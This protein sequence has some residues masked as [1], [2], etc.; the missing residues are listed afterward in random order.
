MDAKV[1]QFIEKHSLLEPGERVLVAY[2]GGPDSACLLVLLRQI[3][4]ATAAVYVNHQLRGEESNQEEEFVR[5]FCV[6]RSIPLYVER[7][8]WKEKPKNLEESARKRRYRNL[9]KVAAEQGFHKVALAHHQDDIAETFLLR[10]IRGSGPY[11]LAG[12][13]P[14]RGI[15]IRPFLEC[16]RVEIL[17]H[18]SKNQVPF[19]QDSTN[20]GLEFRRNRIRSELIPYIEKHFNSAFKETLSRTSLWIHEQNELLSELLTP[21]ENLIYEE[22]GKVKI[23]REPFLRLSSPLRKALFRIA[24]KRSDPSLR[25]NS[26]LLVRLLAAVE[27]QE[28]LE[29]PGFLMVESMPS[30]IEFSGKASQIGYFEVDVPHT[31]NYSFPPGNAHLKFSAES[32][33]RFEETENVAFLDGDKASFPL[34]IRNWKKGDAFCPLG[35]TGRKKLSDYLIDRKIPRKERKRIPLILKDDDLI[36]VA[37]HQIHHEYRV[38]ETTQK[39][40][41]IELLKDV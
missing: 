4:E 6:Q 29:L 40:L 33:I 3:W 20:T 35:M 22:N 1:R 13:Q 31:G 16:S 36:W 19:F 9:S 15:Y 34:Y 28:T 26:R 27:T 30:S 23:S 14:Q 17:K 2:S 38:T 21:Y 37:G 12:L 41:R 11:G 24:L 10:L 18:L 8:S 39:L 32:N 7:I 5:N 25:L